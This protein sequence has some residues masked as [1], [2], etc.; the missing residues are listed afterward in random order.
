MPPPTFMGKFVKKEVIVVGVEEDPHVS[1]T[2]KWLKKKNVGIKLYNLSQLPNIGYFNQLAF[3]AEY[4]ENSLLWCRLAFLPGLDGSSSESLAHSMTLQS[5]WI[6]FFRGLALSHAGP[7]INKVVDIFRWQNKIYQAKEFKRLSIK[8]PHT[9]V[10]RSLEAA[11]GFLK[12]CKGRC[13]MKL[14]STPMPVLLPTGDT[15]LTWNTRLITHETISRMRDDHAETSPLFLQQCIEKAAEWR[16]TCF[17]RKI[18][19]ARYMPDL[20]RDL[21]AVDWRDLH[22]R[23]KPEH[24]KLPS[25]LERNV[26]RLIEFTGLDAC[27]IDVGET[28]D[29]EFVFFEVNPEGQWGW[30]DSDGSYS[31]AMAE[32]LIENA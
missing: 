21:S 15:H 16:I 20:G 24:L 12:K 18:F 28:A 3:D 6:T 9:L 1:N 25:E 13:V 5:E 19:A 10:T 31:N 30:L 11:E 23:V 14:M 7:S 27:T 17:G 26:E 29:G 32:L 8:H 22:R 4:D 2:L